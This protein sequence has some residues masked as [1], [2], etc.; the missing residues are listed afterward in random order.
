M[1]ADLMVSAM[2]ATVME[3][4]EI[5]KRHPEDEQVILERAERQ[6]RLIALGMSVWRSAR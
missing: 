2:L 3:L 6:L 5:D 4:L 1:T